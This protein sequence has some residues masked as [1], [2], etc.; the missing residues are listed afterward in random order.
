MNCQSGYCLKYMMLSDD[1]ISSCHL[2]LP[3]VFT[4]NSHLF[5][6]PKPAQYTCISVSEHFREAKDPHR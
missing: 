1:F 4:Q 2:L 3:E 6:W 5:F